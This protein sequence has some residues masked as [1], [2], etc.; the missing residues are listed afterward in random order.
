MNPGQAPTRT[1][2]M[3]G[4][5]Q[6]AAILL[7]FGGLIW[8]GGR[9]SAEMAS[10]GERVREL[11]QIVSDLARAQAQAAITDAAFGTRLEMAGRRLDEI[12][13]RLDRLDRGP[14]VDRNGRPQ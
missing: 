2:T 10:T 1:G 9:W 14:S 3:L 12:V 11:Q 8:M 13:V 4:T 5:A 7:Q 6:L